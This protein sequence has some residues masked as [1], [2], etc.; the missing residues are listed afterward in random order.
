[1][2]NI[3]ELTAYPIF[4]NGTSKRYIA[5][6]IAPV[7]FQIIRDPAEERVGWMS[8]TTYCVQL[9]G[10]KSFYGT[11]AWHKLY[12]YDYAFKFVA[13]VM[14]DGQKIELAVDNPRRLSYTVN[15]HDDKIYYSDITLSAISDT[16][17]GD[18]FYIEV[19]Y[20]GSGNQTISKIAECPLQAPVEPEKVE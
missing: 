20:A 10:K 8:G 5:C 11:L 16:A 15:E 19:I 4:T 14:R 18:I 9:G 13:Y 6:D 2:A 3:G 17:T 1:M 12:E 7:K